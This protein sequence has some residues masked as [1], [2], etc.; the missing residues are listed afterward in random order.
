MMVWS[1]LDQA[2]SNK[3][4]LEETHVSYY[5]QALQCCLRSCIRDAIQFSSAKG[6]SE[7]DELTN[8]REMQSTQP[9]LVP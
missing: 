2:P 6:G 3:R 9:F 4:S 8:P 1:T 5:T 7:S